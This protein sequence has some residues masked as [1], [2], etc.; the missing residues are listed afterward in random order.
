MEYSKIRR[1]KVKPEKLIITKLVDCKQRSKRD[2]KIN[3][4]EPIEVE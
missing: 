4:V 2:T 3:G 1:Q